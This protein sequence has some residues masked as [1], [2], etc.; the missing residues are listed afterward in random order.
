MNGHLAKHDQRELA[1][2]AVLDDASQSGKGAVGHRNLR[3][4]GEDVTLAA[5]PHQRNPAL[6]GT[7]LGKLGFGNDRNPALMMKDRKRRVR[8]DGRRR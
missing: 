1:V 4:L 6:F 2:P 7:E 8:I 5:L 3:A